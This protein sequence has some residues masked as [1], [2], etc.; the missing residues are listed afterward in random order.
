MYPLGLRNHEEIFEKTKKDTD[1][2]LYDVKE[3]RS[4]TFPLSILTP[5]GV[6]G[7]YYERD[8]DKTMIT[9]HFTVG[10]LRGDLASLTEQDV[11]M[12]TAYVVG[13]NGVVY[14]LFDPK[15]WSYHLGR[16]AIGGNGINSKRSIAIELSNIGPLVREN[17]DLHSVYGTKYCSIEEEEFYVKLESSFRKY[18]YFATFTEEQYKSLR[19]LLAYLCSRF[20]IPHEILPENRRYRLFPSK[21]EAQTFEGICSHVNYR[22]YGK[23]DIG[24]AFDWEKI[25]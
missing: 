5:K 13:R 17:G 2:V 24:P 7:Y 16:G 23:V 12:S 19:E 6:T 25:I 14:Q 10:F 20:N 18:T 11:H 22:G 4:F 8:Y 9:L 1:G 3:D 21:E 15:Y